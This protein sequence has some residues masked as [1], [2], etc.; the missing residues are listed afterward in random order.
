MSW[1]VLALLALGLLIQLVAVVGVLRLPDFY[2]RVHMVGK[3]DTL[4]IMLVIAAVA[5]AEGFNQTSLKL[6]FVIIFYFLANPASA[7]AIGHAAMHRRLKPWTSSREGDDISGTTMA[8]VVP[9][10]EEGK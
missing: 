9:P 6:V 10:A 4:G 1:L 8:R 2:T 3:A 5:V 7:H